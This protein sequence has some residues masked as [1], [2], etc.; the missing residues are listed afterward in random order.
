MVLCTVVVAAVA[1]WAGYRASS[2][3]G[4]EGQVAE[5]LPHGTG[6]QMAGESAPPRGPT[7]GL[8]QIKANLA[9]ISD[10]KELVGIANQHLDNA[11][12]T[13]GKG[14]PQATRMLYTI[15]IAA[16]ERALELQP[17]DPNVLTDL[18]IAYRGLGDPEAAVARFRQAAAVDPSHLQSRFNLGLVLLSDLHSAPQARAAWE[19]YLKIAPNDDP[20]RKD[21]E[22]A[23]K[24]LK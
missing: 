13:E 15:A 18:G 6:A 2:G 14:E 9:K 7:M 24:K 12:N 3:R 23:L 4:Q 16:Y 21:V 22:Q 8:D 10:V 19:D 11:R 17:K 1:Y 5:V 20:N